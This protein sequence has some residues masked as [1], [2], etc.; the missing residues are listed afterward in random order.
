L[1]RIGN[2][3]CVAVLSWFVVQIHGREL[4]GGQI[5]KLRQ[6]KRGMAFSVACSD[7]EKGVLE[8]GESVIIGSIRIVRFA[9]SSHPIMK[10]QRSTNIVGG[11]DT[12]DGNTE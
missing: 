9:L 8:V 1:S 3:P 11:D 2:I 6:G 10:L 5:G 7:T 4:F 12:S